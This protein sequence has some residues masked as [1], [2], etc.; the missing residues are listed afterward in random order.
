MATNYI[1]AGTDI[2]IKS[3][4]ADDASAQ[5]TL[6]R[7]VK[8]DDG[9]RCRYVQF[10]GPVNAGMVVKRCLSKVHLAATHISTGP[11]TGGR[12]F[13]A[14]SQ[15]SLTVANNFA[16]GY[17]VLKDGIGEG[18]MRQITDYAAFSASKTTGI[19]AGKGIKINLDYP[20]QVSPTTA[21]VA[22]LVQPWRVLQST[23]AICEIPGGVALRDHSTSN[24]FGWAQEGGIAAVQP[25]Q[26]DISPGLAIQIGNVS[27]GVVRKVGVSSQDDISAVDMHAIMGYCIT[28][29]SAHAAWGL[30]V[31]DI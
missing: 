21:T 27:G 30:A 10:R 18:Q 3:L 14:C 1:V 23:G 2:P 28:D 12:G 22:D 9:R 15:A 13:L 16:G 19:L 29:P 4:Y 11:T 6:G 20:W 26:S 7:M 24:Y 8:L 31:L 5:E 25:E 17:V